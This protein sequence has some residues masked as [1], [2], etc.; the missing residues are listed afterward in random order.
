MRA[1]RHHTSLKWIHLYVERWLRA[2]VRLA[3]GTVQ[4]R[5]RGTPQGGVISPLLAN[6]FMH[7]A[8]DE[9][10]RRNFPSVPFERYVDDVVVHCVSENQAR[11]VLAAVRQ[12]LRECHLEL[13]PEKTRVV[14]CKD[15]NRL[16]TYKPQSFDFLGFCFRPRR[17]RNRKG[18]KFV[19]FLPAISPKAAKSIRE[20]VRSWRLTLVGVHWTLGE[21]AERINLIVRGWLNYYGRFYRSEC[22]RVLRYVNRVL[23]RWAT[24]KYKRFKR[25]KRRAAA[26]LSRV[27]DRLPELLILW[28]DGVTPRAAGW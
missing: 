19:A 28:R 10:M 25:R 13:H 18:Q 16:G 3:D 7:Y 6:L 5:E 24:K 9:W 4:A 20:Q 23:V 22:Q 2:P 12:R 1:V 11:Y 21:L 27:A 8:F 15:S 17:A 14:Y 26:W